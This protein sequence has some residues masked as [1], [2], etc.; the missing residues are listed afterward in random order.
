MSKFYTQYREEFSFIEGYEKYLVTDKGRVYSLHSNGFRRIYKTPAG[1]LTVSLGN[2]NNCAKNFFVHRLVGKAFIPN[3]DNKPQINH[4]D[5]IKH[6]NLLINLE[7]VTQQENMDHAVKTGLITK[8]EIKH[9]ESNKTFSCAEEAAET[10]NIKKTLISGC[11]SGYKKTIS[12]GTTDKDYL[13]FR[14]LKDSNDSYLL[15]YDKVQKNLESHR[16]AKNKRK[17]EKNAIIEAQRPNQRFNN[18]KRRVY[19]MEL[20]TF[21]PSMGEAGRELGINYQNIYSCCKGEST[22]TSYPGHSSRLSW[23]YESALRKDTLGNYIFS[24]IP[25]IP[26]KIIKF[27]KPKNNTKTKRAKEIKKIKKVK[28]I[29]CLN[30]GHIFE[31][32]KEAEQKTGI[33]GSSIAAH[34]KGNLGSAGKDETGIPLFWAYEDF[35][36]K[37]A[38][39]NYILPYIKI[40]MILCIDTNKKYKTITDASRDTG[41][42]EQDISSCVNGISES[43]GEDTNNN[44]LTWKRIDIILNN[45]YK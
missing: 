42:E 21:F 17:R 5:G 1:Y 3:P 26:E 19:C 15:K 2:G 39:G 18:R 38:D 29:I 27:K 25:K 30:S 37:N 36:D 40:R 4:I 10:L 13:T 33:A 43:A 12:I 45:N 32:C 34:C 23:I 11:C 41:I 44:P 28:K 7:W 8:K 14:Y 6:N 16:Q 9:L 35:L 22:S 31:S 20:D 24:D